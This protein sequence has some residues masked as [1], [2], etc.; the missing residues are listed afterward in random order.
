[1]PQKFPN[2]LPD[3]PIGF[4]SPEDVDALNRVLGMHFIRTGAANVAE[5]F[6]EECGLARDDAA[7]EKFVELHRIVGR[8]RV[9]DV[10]PALE[11]AAIN[12]S[13]L[14]ARHSTLEFDLHRSKFIR[15]VVSS[16][17][18]TSS[19]DIDVASTAI[20]PP[21]AYSRQY[22]PILLKY[23]PQKAILDQINRL[24]ASL[25][26]SAH[27]ERS[28]YKDLLDDGAHTELETA[29]SKEYCALLLLS[30]HSPLQVVGEIAA[31]EALARIEK[32]KKIMKDKRSEW[33]IGDELMVEVPLS[34]ANRYHSIF[35][36][37]VSKE[38]ASEKNPPMRLGCG[39]V[40]SK[41][42]VER[43]TKSGKIKCP[44]C[45]VESTEPLR[46]YF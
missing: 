34:P 8:L 20:P 10:Q 19:M 25:A 28:P 31:N 22:F 41:E 39:H 9:Q 1:V 44:Y 35:A 14:Q 33:D 40:I 16:A 6:F 7:A 5:V 13:F 36:C 29:F 24:V 17:E 46:V 27:L 18:D 38:Q 45:P 3:S 4:D 21:I 30:R 15:L 32:S 2:P 43:L 37:P 42:S 11:W 12:R 26:F 23:Y